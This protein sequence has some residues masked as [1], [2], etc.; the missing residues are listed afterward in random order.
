MP[1]GVGPPATTPRGGRRRKNTLGERDGDR[2]GG[3]DV[4]TTTPSSAFPVR[5]LGDVSLWLFGFGTRFSPEKD[6]KMI[7]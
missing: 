6:R 2:G 1:W 5:L 4:G 3:G 7:N